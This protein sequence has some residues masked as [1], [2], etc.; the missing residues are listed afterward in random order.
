[1]INDKMIAALN[2]Q[3]NREM[4][5]AYLY[6]SMSS[7]CNM[8]G[9][10]GFANWF[11]VQYHEEMIHA[12]KIYEY[13][14]R[15]GGEVHLKTIQ[16]PPHSFESPLDMFTKTLEH[17]QFITRSINDLMELAIAEKDHASQIFLE[18][19]VTEQV[20]EEENDNDIIQQLKIIKDNAHALLMLDRELAARITTVPTD[21]SKG[22]ESSMKQTSA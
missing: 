7:H 2:E 11:M 19:Y 22:I 9:L 3:I 10:K 6:M 4:Y 12:M 20:E 15:Q 13:I 5:S 17:E 14:Q 21:F 8:V 16:A 18:W 1:M